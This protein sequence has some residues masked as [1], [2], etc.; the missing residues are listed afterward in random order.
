MCSMTRRVA[1][2]LNAE[3][4]NSPSPSAWVYIALLWGRNG[5]GHSRGFVVHMPD[6]NREYAG[7]GEFVAGQRPSVRVNK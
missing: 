6:V 4:L 3:K 7:T 1:E 2:D 5:L